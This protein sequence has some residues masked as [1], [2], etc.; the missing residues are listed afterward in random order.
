[1]SIC[2]LAWSSECLRRVYF[3]VPS[4]SLVYVHDTWTEY[5]PQPEHC[6]TAT[7]SR[8]PYFYLLVGEHS[9]GGSF[10]TIFFLSP[11]VESSFIFRSFHVVRASVSYSYDGRTRLCWKT[12]IVHLLPTYSRFHH[13]CI[14]T[15]PTKASN[16]QQSQLIINNSSQCIISTP[17]TSVYIE[18]LRCLPHH[19]TS[20]KAYHSS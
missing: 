20:Q 2:P 8:S 13:K 19:H 1:M 10:P 14:Y 3:L 18:Q 12:Q 16:I 6:D 9:Q 5:S 17:R 11:L 7:F 15:S 4:L